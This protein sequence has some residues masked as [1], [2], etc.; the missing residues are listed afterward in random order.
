MASFFIRDPEDGALC[1]ALVLELH[2]IIEMMSA[3][4]MD[5]FDSRARLY[6]FLR[7]HEASEATAVAVEAED[8]SGLL[9]PTTIAADAAV[10]APAGPKTRPKE[11]IKTARSFKQQVHY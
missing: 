11:P 9:A 1:P 6:G 10:V 5:I 8:T 4:D 7:P 2:D 3:S